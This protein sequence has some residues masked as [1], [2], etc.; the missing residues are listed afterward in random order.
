M[1]DALLRVVTDRIGSALRRGD[2]AA[3]IGGDEFAVVLADLRAPGDVE[4]LSRRICRA[5]IGPAAIEEHVVEVGASF[6][7]VSYP[8]DGAEIG[9]LMRH[10][11]L[12]LYQAKSNREKCIVAFHS[13]LAAAAVARAELGN[14]LRGAIARDELVLHY[15]PQ[16]DLRTGRVATV[17][18]LVRWPRNGKLIPPGVFIPVAETSGAIRPLGIWVLVAACA[19]QARW[20]RDGHDLTVAINVSPA[21]VGDDDFLRVLDEA[22]RAAGIGP[23]ALEF[24]ITEGLLI[25]TD[26]PSVTSFLE[27]CR[28]RGIGLALDDFGIGYS[29]LGHL[30]RLPISKLKID[31]SFV[32]KIGEPEGE[33]LIEA[34]VDLGHRLGKR[35]VAE[36]VETAAQLEHLRG[37]GCDEAQ[38]FFFSPPSAPAELGAF[39]RAHGS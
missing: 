15:Q 11:D 4:M 7:T 33:T 39:L 29:S 26:E 36:G 30:G 9:R 18:A 28:T 20:R 25:D 5:L 6:G 8:E 16:I 13:G 37:I 32:A 17:E 35:V 23:E 3:R 22:T 1:G 31:R 34:M 24:E 21:Q 2:T 14:D 27:A 10:A 38:G 12:A 19:E